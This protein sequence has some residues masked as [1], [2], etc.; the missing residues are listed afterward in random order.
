MNYDALAKNQGNGFG[1]SNPY[2][3]HPRY[4]EIKMLQFII[5]EAL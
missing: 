1:S 3:P 2:S 4:K 5:E